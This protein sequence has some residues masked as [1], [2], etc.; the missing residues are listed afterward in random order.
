MCYPMG[1]SWLTDWELFFKMTVSISFKSSLLEMS[2]YM[3]QGLMNPN[4]LKGSLDDLGTWT[5]TSVCWVVIT[6]QSRIPTSLLFAFH[7][8]HFPWSG[9]SPVS[10]VRRRPIAEQC[11]HVLSLPLGVGKSGYKAILDPVQ[12]WAVKWHLEAASRK[13]IFQNPSFTKEKRFFSS[14]WENLR[15][16]KASFKTHLLTRTPGKAELI[17][18]WGWEETCSGLFFND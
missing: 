2:Q 5:T 4:I 14:S 12:A 11:W 3:A 10:E 1:R 13:V 18:T 16:P 6:E 8:A 7:R 9:L 17:L 15:F